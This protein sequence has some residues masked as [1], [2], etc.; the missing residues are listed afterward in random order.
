MQTLLPFI[1][2][3]EHPWILVSARVP[4][5]KALV[6]STVIQIVPNPCS[7]G[8]DLSITFWELKIVIG[9]ERVSCHWERAEKKMEKTL[10]KLI[11]SLSKSSVAS[12][13]RSSQVPP[14]IPVTTSGYTA[15][16][17]CSL[18]QLCPTLCNPM[19]YIARQAS[20]PSLSPRVCSNSCPLSQWCHPT[21]SSSVAPFS[22][23]PQSFPESGSF[24][25]S[26]LFASGDQSIIA[27]ASA[28]VLPMSI[29]GWFILG[30]T[31]FFS[32]MAKGL[33]RVFSSTT[34][35]KHQIFGTQ[36]SL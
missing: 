11:R 1:W 15:C 8:A 9:V 24:P 30:L 14:N 19:D 17:C 32:L 5:A 20:C 23:C 6:P 7:L 27:S 2:D 29:Q 25:M 31:G 16:C 26:Q 22:S 33:L 12:W 35:G 3:L 10:H 4:G 34:I 18:A 21:V 36:L 28:P 13:M